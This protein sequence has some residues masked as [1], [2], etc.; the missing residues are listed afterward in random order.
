MIYEFISR[1]KVHYPV[2]KMCQVLKV[3]RSS[4]YHWDEKR[5]YLNTLKKEKTTYLDQRITALF[6]SNRQIYGSTRICEALRREGHHY[7][8]SYI[9]RRMNT[10]GLKSVLRRKYVVTTKSN[11]TLPIAENLLNREFQSYKLSEKWVSDITYIRVKDDWNY[12]T[13]IIDLADRKVVGWSFSEDMT[14]KNTVVNAYLNARMNRKITRPLIFHSD[15]GIQY[16]SKD[17]RQIL[18]PNL[19]IRQSMSRKGDCWDNAVAESFFKSIKHEWLYRFKFNS[20][21]EAYLQ[22]K[23]YINW[24]NTKRLHSAIGYKTPLEKE[25]ELK[26]IINNVA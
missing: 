13:S 3:S 25:I 11:H 1:N 14:T 6:Y 5:H 26:T 22:I 4:F 7:S 15:R 21:E 17:L 24:Y 19:L 16:T 23:D 2:E 12:L 18:E 9:A 8:R 10:M 20:Y